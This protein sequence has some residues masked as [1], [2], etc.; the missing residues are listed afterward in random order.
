MNPQETGGIPMAPS[1]KNTSVTADPRRQY[2]VSSGLDGALAA[3]LVLADGTEHLA[4]LVNVSAGGTCLRWSP[5]RA[6]VLNIGQQV[7]LRIQS[8]TAERSIT[9]RARVRWLGADDEGNIR[10]GLEFQDLAEVFDQLSPTLW[11]LFNARKTRR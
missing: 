3:A 6:V 11:R 5:G 1:S 10:Y 7:K 9:V 8:C 2:R 4:E